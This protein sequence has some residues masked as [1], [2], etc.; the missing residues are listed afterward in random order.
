MI[1]DCKESFSGVDAPSD[2]RGS[3]DSVESLLSKPQN[4]WIEIPAVCPTLDTIKKAAGT[5]H[6]RSY[7]RVFDRTVLEAIE[8]VQA[9]IEELRQ[10]KEDRKQWE[11]EFGDAEIVE[12]PTGGGFPPRNTAPFRLS[13]EC[14]NPS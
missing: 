12:S 10:A 3:S 1:T 2:G 4:I 11:L 6:Q 14:F 13:T 8:Q 7:I 5:C 9:R